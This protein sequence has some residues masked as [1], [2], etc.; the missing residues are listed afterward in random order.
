MPE[1]VEN[2]VR[3]VRSNPKQH[4]TI[5]NHGET[6]DNVHNKNFAS[7]SVLHIWCSR[8]E[9][10]ISK[11]IASYSTRKPKTISPH[12]TEEIDLSNTGSSSRGSA[13]E[14][15]KVDDN[16]QTLKSPP[17]IHDLE[18]M[19][20]KKMM[21]MIK[22]STVTDITQNKMSLLIWATTH[23]QSTLQS[24]TQTKTTLEAYQMQFGITKYILKLTN[25]FCYDWVLILGNRFCC[26]CTFW[27]AD[28]TTI[29]HQLWETDRFCC[30]LHTDFGETDKACCQL[31]TN[32]GE[33]DRFCCQLLIVIGPNR[34]CCDIHSRFFF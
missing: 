33:T 30:Q 12:L 23:W 10:K 19:S 25:R 15:N 11:P 4:I 27:E 16:S 29:A 32:F 17:L 1:I 3:N 2:T 22:H 13:A 9:R 8:L 6:E 24:K 34:F 20:D 18:V 14:N 28:S 26:Y 21:L 7:K 31:H 5:C